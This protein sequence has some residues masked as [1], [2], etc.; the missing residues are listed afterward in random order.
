MKRL[1][2]L[3][4]TVIALGFLLE[5]QKT[6]NFLISHFIGYNAWLIELV[7]DWLID[8]LTDLKSN[9]FPVSSC[10][11]LNLFCYVMYDIHAQ[12]SPIN[13]KISTVQNYNTRSS[14]EWVFLCKIFENW[15]DEKSFIR[16]LVSL[17]EISSH[18]QW[19]NY[20]N[21]IQIPKQNKGTTPW[22]VTMLKWLY[23]SLPADSEIF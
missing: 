8:W 12:K 9:C 19:N 10:F 6:C 2:V 15:Q 7:S 3:E 16:R 14:Q 1:L 23:W 17:S 21:Q 5:H 18:F 20:I 22:C 11:F 13:L 4:K